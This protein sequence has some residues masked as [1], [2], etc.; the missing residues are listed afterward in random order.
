MHLRC[1]SCSSAPHEAGRCGRGV[2]E[3][4]DSLSVRALELPTVFEVSENDL[5]LLCRVLLKELETLLRKRAVQDLYRLFCGVGHL[6]TNGPAI[7]LVPDA[8]CITGCLDAIQLAAHRT[9][10]PTAPALP[11]HG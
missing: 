6:D 3:P 10:A 1:T 11:C 5:E 2:T 4:A 9:W 8:P 7:L